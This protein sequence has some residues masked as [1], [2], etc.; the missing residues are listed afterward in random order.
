MLNYWVKC[1]ENTENLN[2]KVFKTKNNR[3][4]MQSKSAAC[5]S[6]KSA[7]I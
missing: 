3:I 6:K 5:G 7:L 2:S 4:I 1:R